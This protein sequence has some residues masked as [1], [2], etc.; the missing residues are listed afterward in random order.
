MP[1][2]RRAATSTGTVRLTVTEIYA[3]SVL[4]PILRDFHDAHPSIR[5][6]V[7][8]SEALSDLGAGAADVALR[9]TDRPSGAGVFGRR[10]RDDDWAIYCSRDY[11]A[12]HGHPTRRGELGAHP[13]IGGGEPKIWRMYHAWLAANG[14][15]DN[16]AMHYD[17]ATG[18]LVGGARR[19]RARDAALHRRRRRSRPAALPAAR[20]R[21]RAR[22]MAAD[23]RACPPRAARPAADR[24]PGG[25]AGAAMTAPED[26]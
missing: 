26:R 14:L 5:I 24:F 4:G 19:V 13:I 16:V 3:V 20:A 25:A 11:A 21:Q 17:T 22:A 2:R 1:R 8:T 18:L 23:P 12:R 15:L 9:T 7:D 10:L 6:E